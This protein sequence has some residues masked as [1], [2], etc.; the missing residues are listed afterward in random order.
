MPIVNADY[1]SLN[2]DEM[3][4]SI[5]LK[6]KHMPMLIGSFLEES[7][8]ILSNI[9]VAID[10]SNYPDLKMHSHSIKGSAGNLKFT[11]IYEMAKEMELSAA[12]SN[13]SFDYNAYLEAISAAVA[14]IPS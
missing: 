2:F 7:G 12:E 5:G 6:P 14:T 9:K 13:A 10:S 1:S 11:E 3:A 8:P 4:A